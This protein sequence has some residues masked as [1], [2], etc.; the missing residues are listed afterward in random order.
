MCCL[1]ERGGK[2]CWCTRSE[3]GRRGREREREKERERERERGRGRGRER[4]RE[5]GRSTQENSRVEML[6]KVAG[7]K[8]TSMRLIM[9]RQ[10]SWV[11]PSVFRSLS[12]HARG[13][14]TCVIVATQL[15]M[16]TQLGWRALINVH[17]AL[18]H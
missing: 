5:G 18:L 16:L 8:D 4:E 12:G 7:T 15:P 17:A 9:L 13:G 1:E 3:G 6:E 2:T 14:E 11:N 10:E